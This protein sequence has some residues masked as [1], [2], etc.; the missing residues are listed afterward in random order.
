MLHILASLQVD[1]VFAASYREGSRS[2]INPDDSA[3]NR[4]DFDR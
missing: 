3:R 2:G 4:L 1:D